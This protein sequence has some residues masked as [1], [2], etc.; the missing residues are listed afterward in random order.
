LGGCAQIQKCK[1][2]FTRRR[3]LASG[4]GAGQSVF[5]S[6]KVRAKDIISPRQLWI[7]PPCLTRLRYNENALTIN[8]NMEKIGRDFISEES[9]QYKFKIGHLIASSLSGFL[10]GVI[11]ASLV[12]VFILWLL[13]LKQSSGI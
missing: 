5:R 8:I 6:K 13:R 4:G 2:Y 11:F 7:T 9:R 3:A 10:A 12:W 1:E